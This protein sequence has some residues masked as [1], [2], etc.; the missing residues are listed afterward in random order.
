MTPTPNTP[1]ASGQKQEESLTMADFRLTSPAF[2]QDQDLPSRFSADGGNISPPLEWTGVPEGTKEL[3]LICDDP[4]APYGVFTHWI[5]YGVAANETGLP[6]GIPDDAVIDE[7]VELMQ[8][9]NE[10]D[11]S[12]YT[13]PTVLDDEDDDEPVPHRYFFRLYALDTELPLAPGARRDEVRQACS[14]H[15]IGS[16]ELVVIS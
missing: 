15:V 11:E 14:G 3:L 8:G 10:F 6:E 16:A 5:V 13:G 12:G 2:Q 9:L 4:D 1:A 7:P